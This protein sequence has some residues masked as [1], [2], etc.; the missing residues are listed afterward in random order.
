MKNKLLAVFLLGSF[1]LTCLAATAWGED[2]RLEIKTNLKAKGKRIR[3][4]VDKGPA[5]THKYGLFFIGI[6]L[7]PQIA[8]W[9]EDAYGSYIETLYTT[10][11]HD[12]RMEVLPYWSHRT[13]PKHPELIDAVTGA[14]PKSDWLLTS[15]LNKEQDTIVVKA[16]L[17]NSFD[18]NDYFTKDNSGVNGQPSVVYSTTVDIYNRENP[19]VMKLIGFGSPNGSDGTL[20]DE[21]NKLTTAK[22]IAKKITVEMY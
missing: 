19:Y 7:S 9:T 15:R 1:C 11:F 12:G 20:C 22:E 4:L 3:V 2:Q 6:D 14:T 8:I 21:V 5:W 16:E 13:D 18:Y 17:N 10:K